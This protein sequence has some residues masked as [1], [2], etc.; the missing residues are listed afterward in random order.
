MKLAL[1]TLISFILSLKR[2]GWGESEF[3][4]AEKRS[5]LVLPNE[6]RSGI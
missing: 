1:L 4:N 2:D 5:D 6:F 3:V